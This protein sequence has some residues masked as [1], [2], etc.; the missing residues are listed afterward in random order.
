MTDER[1]RRRPVFRTPL[2]ESAWV[3]AQEST[4][5]FEVAAT[6]LALAE[7]LRALEIRNLLARRDAA[8]LALAEVLPPLKQLAKV[9][10]QEQRTA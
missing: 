5:W 7:A 1:E 9:T 4:K 3:A 2:E 10:E 6:L 8:D